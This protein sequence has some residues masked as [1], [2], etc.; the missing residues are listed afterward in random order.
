ME[1]KTTGNNGQPIPENED[2]NQPKSDTEQK[3]TDPNITELKG[4]IDPKEKLEP[5]GTDNPDVK[6]M[7]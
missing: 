6:G 3:Q 4:F 5:E 7:P 2:M 1:Q